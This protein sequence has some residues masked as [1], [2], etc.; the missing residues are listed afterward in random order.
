MKTRKFE[1]I[2]CPKCGREYLP[3]E[4]YIPHTFFGK[5]RDIVRDVYGRIL[6][7]DGSSVDLFETYTCDKC[8]T[9]F[10]VRA[11]MGF[12]VETTKL[13]NFDEPYSTPLHTN[14][15]FMDEIK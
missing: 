13:D 11:K 6:D 8:N 7:Y 12:T 9:T 15:L 10:Q 1:I 2:E 14:T 5:P 3:A 4:I